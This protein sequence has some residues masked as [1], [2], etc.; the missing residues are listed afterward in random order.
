MKKSNQFLA[1][2]GLLTLFMVLFTDVK[3]VQAYKKIDLSDPFKNYISLELGPYAVLKLS[4]SNGYPIE[5]NYADEDELKV[6]RSRTEHVNHSIHKDTL[7]IEFTGA[8]ISKQ[9]NQSSNSPAAIIIQKSRIPEI[10]ATDIHCRISDF[11]IDEMKLSLEGHAISEIKDCQ[12]GRMKVNIA[13]QGHLAFY[14]Q[15]RINSL[16]LKMENA[17]VAFLKNVNLHHI[18]PDLGDS[19]SLVLSNH[20]FNALVE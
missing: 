7:F 5:V 20:V 4:G 2:L 19:V 13:Q 17:S 15:N 12:L 18:E 16:V 14:H 11:E 3:L 9:Q 10:I 1:I 6:L 8:R